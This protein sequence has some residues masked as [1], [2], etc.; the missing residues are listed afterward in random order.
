MS[1]AQ[2]NMDTGDAPGTVPV[3]SPLWFVFWVLL[4]SLSWLLPVHFPPWSTFPADAW[5]AIITLIGATILVVRVRSRLT[6][7][8]LPC[9]VAGLVLL[10]W[11]QWGAGLLPYVG[12]AWVSSAYLLGFLLALLVGAQWEKACPGQLAHAL[13]MAIGLAAVA[14][15]GLQFYTWLRLSDNGILGLWS[16]GQVSNRPSANLGQ[17]NQ[18]STFLVWGLLATLWAYL[19]K[20]LGDASGIFV[21]GF[22]L[23][24]LAMTQSRTG[25]LVVSCL[26]GVLWL[27]RHLWPWRRLPLAATGLYLG[28]LAYAPLF[29]WLDGALLL[30]QDAISLRLKEPGEA[31]LQ[32]WQLFA[33]AIL[34][35]PFFGYGMSEVSVAQMAVA[36]KFAS[37][38]S[39]FSRSHNLLLDLLLWFGI[40]VGLALAGALA[41]WF[42]LRA[43]SVRQPQEVVLLML[44]AAVGVHALLEFPLQY[45]YFLIPAGLVMGILNVRLKA[46]V[47]GLTPRWSLAVLLLSGALTIG[48][49]LRDY[50]RLDDSYAL[51]RLEQSLIGEGR[52][53]MG[54]PPDVWVLTHLREWIKLARA[55][56]GA[57]MSAQALR[58]LENAASAYP[59]MGSVYLFAK[60]LALN[61]QPDKARTWLAKICKFSDARDC[62]VAQRSWEKEAFDDPRTLAIRWPG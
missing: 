40:P 47:M 38:G 8:F 43:R 26:L 14:S 44:L 37:L 1:P 18:L 53:P 10:P 17:P 13:F 9:L 41:H 39:I 55:K 62:R 48:V 21:A 61:G 34:E 32:A 57:N 45:A 42:W 29:R 54:G 31:R 35:R 52:G 2:T 16:L 46:H 20:R 51:L 25:L 15:V 59:S 3:M 27:C 58:D 4:L 7:Y 33:Q 23:L 19:Y 11:L 24:G 56:P 12:Q 49:T 36:E 28:Y 6:W 22:L 50:E 30:G 5:M 60:A